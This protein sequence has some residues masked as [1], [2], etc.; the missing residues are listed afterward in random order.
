[1][2]VK[3]IVSYPYTIGVSI[4]LYKKYVIFAPPL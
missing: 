2:L 3:E 4:F 1:V